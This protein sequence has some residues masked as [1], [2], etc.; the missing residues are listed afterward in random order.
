M[1]NLRNLPEA[2]YSPTTYLRRWRKQNTARTEVV[3]SVAR[4]S[5]AH[6]RI[7]RGRSLLPRRRA[8]IGSRP[9][10]ARGAL[11]LQPP[12]KLRP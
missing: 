7:S 5:R 1:E 3:H 11:P 6:R 2:S 12:L 4:G 9:S 8:P 10:R